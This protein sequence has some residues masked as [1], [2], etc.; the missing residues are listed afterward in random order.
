MWK[1]TEYVITI[2]CE[3][4]LSK[5]P[6]KCAKAVFGVNFS[7]L[8]TKYGLHTVRSY[9]N[10]HKRTCINPLYTSLYM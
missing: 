8:Q 2:V 10:S 6:Y 7:T 3:N 9:N 1:W 5:F 4:E